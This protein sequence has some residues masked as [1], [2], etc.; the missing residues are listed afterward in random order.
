MRF[1]MIVCPCTW[2]WSSATLPFCNTVPP[3]AET[4]LVCVLGFVVCCCCS[5]AIPVWTW[6]STSFAQGLHVHT[7]YTT[8]EFSATKDFVTLWT[9][10]LILPT[11]MT[12]KFF[13]GIVDRY[14]SLTYHEIRVRV[15]KFLFICNP[16][17]IV[18]HFNY[19][20]V[21]SIS[22]PWRQPVL[23]IRS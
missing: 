4:F 13:P 3:P 2:D 10:V 20:S 18:L 12:Y 14:S 5:K 16:Q 15:V 21:S 22:H 17:S 7:R 23:K 8:G 9:W 11:S 19:L 6:A 1:H